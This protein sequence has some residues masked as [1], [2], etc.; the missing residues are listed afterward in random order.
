MCIEIN[1]DSNL[2]VNVFHI[3]LSP[4]T[5]Q[6]IKSICPCFVGPGIRFRTNPVGHCH[7]LSGF[8]ICLR[9]DN[10]FE[11]PSYSLALII[12]NINALFGMNFLGLNLFY[13]NINDFQ[14]YFQN[15]F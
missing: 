3:A 8:A 12:W 4:K 5:T 14:I 11:T 15:E 1:D 2:R 7:L 13:F 6:L 10:G 9:S